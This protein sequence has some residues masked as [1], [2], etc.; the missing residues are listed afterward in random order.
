MANRSGSKGLLHGRLKLLAVTAVVVAGLTAFAV[1][2]LLG[3]GVFTLHREIS[4]LS[5]AIFYPDKL[6]L[7]TD[8]HCRGGQQI[9]ML[10]ETDVDVQVK[11]TAPYR[12]IRMSGLDCEPS[13]EVRLQKPLGDRVVVDTHSGQ[14][15][16]LTTATSFSLRTPPDWRTVDVP[17]WAGQPGFSLQLPH[18]WEL[19]ELQG[20]DS[21]VG[22]VIGDGVR[23][24]L[25][26]GESPWDLEVAAGP[27]HLYSV[28]YR[29]VGG[30]EAKLITSMVPGEGYTGVYFADLGGPS[31]NLV[32]EHLTTEQ[33]ETAFAV[34]GSI[35]LLGNE[36]GDA[37]KAGPP[38]P[39]SGSP[40]IEDPP[41]DA[42]LN[43][44]QSIA[45]REGISLQE[46]IDRYAWHDNFSL[47]V[48]GIRE[49]APTSFARAEIAGADHA[50]IAFRGLPPRAALDVLDIFR[51]SHTAI[52][53]EVRTGLGFT[54]A[55]IEMAIPA[56]HYA[57]LESSG[58]RDA[59]TSFDFPKGRITTTV[60]LE[61]TAPDSV[62]QDLRAIASQR[63]I[64]ETRPDILDTISVAVVRSR[65]P[66]LG[67]DESSTDKRQE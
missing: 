12:L 5:G 16:S 55:E 34:F 11:V 35:R 20:I 27:P 1:W 15:V 2:L 37:G 39:E 60:V 42:E 43:D 28:L 13:V 23:L 14:T 7:V 9:S 25:D 19:K 44:L 4:V 33:R 41:S 26:Y 47:T 59:I 8:G 38:V 50:W 66:V 49:V 46:A 58:V 45:N 36:A 21:Y 22:E 61:S 32:G 18:G 6:L 10:R 62:L 51:N 63:L 29:D 52:S 48:S 31:L 24:S 3:F 30:F 54:E 67:G 17:G 57:V 40:G 56:V 65:H 64:D 53:V